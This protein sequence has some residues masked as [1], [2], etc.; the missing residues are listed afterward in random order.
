MKKIPLLTKLIFLAGALF[1]GIVLLAILSYDHGF[2]FINTNMSRLGRPSYNPDWYWLYT[3]A[4]L[5]AGALLVPYYWQLRHLKSEDR[6]LN[7]GLILLIAVGFLSCIG[8]TGVAVF[9]AD[10]WLSHRIFGGMYFISDVLVMI[11]AAYVILK[12]PKLNKAMVLICI[13]SAALDLVFLKS[14]GKLSW[15]EWS[16]VF[17]SFVLAC[18]IGIDCIQHGIGFGTPLDSAAESSLSS[19]QEE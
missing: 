5:V 3:T 19:A 14:G 6:M 10:H 15:S 13:A 4:C 16:T 7:S 18:W 17:L 8:L 11:V 2:S 12:H 9:N 1:Y